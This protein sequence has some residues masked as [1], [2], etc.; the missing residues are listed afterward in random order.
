MVG[1]LMIYIVLPIRGAIAGLSI[2]IQEGTKREPIAISL[3][4][5]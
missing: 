3:W 4:S 5:K 1:S 2:G